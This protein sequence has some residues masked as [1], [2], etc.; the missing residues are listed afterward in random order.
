MVER[1]GIIPEGRGSR[2]SY[3]PGLRSGETLYVSGQVPIDPLTGEK[4][5]EFADQV[6]LA[7]ENVRRV[8]TAAGG[9]LEDAVR[10]GVYLSDLANFEAMDQIYR[11]FF[12]EPLPA[13][14]TIQAGLNAVD[15]EIDAIISLTR[16]D[17]QP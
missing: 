14:T 12:E 1:Q 17:T 13:R 11:T 15:I 9:R 5:A 16:A 8:A 6:R 10:V 7:L 3:S 2:Y 4:P